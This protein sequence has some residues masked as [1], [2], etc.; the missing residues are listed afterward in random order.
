M[1]SYDHIVVWQYFQAQSEEHG[2]T[3][4]M[5]LHYNFPTAAEQPYEIFARCGDGCGVMPRCFDHHLGS[6]VTS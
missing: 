2:C 1:P 6:L 5:Y 4:D 3:Y